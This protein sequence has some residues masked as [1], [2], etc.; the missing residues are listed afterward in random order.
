MRKFA[1][2]FVAVLFAAATVAPVPFI[3]MDTTA[4]AAKKGGG[5][6]DVAGKCGTGKY[7]DKKKKKCADASD[8]K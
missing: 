5:K 3:G 4:Y 8:K 1:L 2:L 6:K 7:F